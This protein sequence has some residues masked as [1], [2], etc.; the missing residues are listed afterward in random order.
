MHTPA[1]PLLRRQH[2]RLL[3]L[4]ARKALL[5]GCCQPYMPTL[6]YA[7]SPL[8]PCRQYGRL[9]ALVASKAPFLT[10]SSI[11]TGTNLRLIIPSIP[12]AVRAVAGAGGQ[13]GAAPRVGRLP[14]PLRPGGPG[15]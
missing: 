10:F 7:C 5:F 8:L 6:M 2:G 9:L 3:A 13:Q 1:C 12:Q 4:A 11:V 15:G 14:V